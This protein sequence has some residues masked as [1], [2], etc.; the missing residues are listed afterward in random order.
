M[1][2]ASCQTALLRVIIHT[3]YYIAVCRGLWLFTLGRSTYR[4]P[5]RLQLA[6]V[7][8]FSHNPIGPGDGPLISFP[9]M[10][11]RRQMKLIHLP[12]QGKNTKTL[13]RMNDMGL[14]PMAHRL[15]VYCSPN[16]ANHSHSPCMVSRLP[17]LVMVDCIGGKAACN[18]CLYS[19]AGL[20]GFEP[21]DTRVK[22]LCLTTWR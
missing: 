17:W 10:G 6:S 21:T 13:D 19:V 14:E 20:V 8:W 18:N 9:L 1:R 15:K 22:V 5:V 4:P 12:S 11:E 2:L 16:W 3:A 7:G